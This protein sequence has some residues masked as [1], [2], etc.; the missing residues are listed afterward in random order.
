MKSH[1]NDP[2]VIIIFLRKYFLPYFGY[3]QIIFS[4][5]FVHN[6][7][8]FDQTY[9][10]PDGVLITP[11]PFN[12]LGFSTIEGYLDGAYNLGLDPDFNNILHTSNQLTIEWWADGTGWQ[13]GNDGPQSDESWAIDNVEIVINPVPEPSTLLLLCSGLIGLVGIKRSLKKYIIF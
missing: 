4:E 3:T 7:R 5:T 11:S 12:N 13:G 1:L 8:D 6:P 10:P 2:I 9:I